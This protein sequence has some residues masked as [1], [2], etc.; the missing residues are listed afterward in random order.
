MPI[1]VEEY[2]DSWSKI[3]PCFE[4]TIPCDGTGAVFLSPDDPARLVDV[5]VERTDFDDN[6]GLLPGKRRADSKD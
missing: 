6:T 3:Y 4:Q 2:C 1:G 5:G